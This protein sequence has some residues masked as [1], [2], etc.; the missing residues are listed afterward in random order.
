MALD[1]ATKGCRRIC[2]QAVCEVKEA[3]LCA[4]SDAGI[5][6]ADI[7]QLD[8]SFSDLSDPFEKL[9]TAYMRERFYKE[10]FNYKVS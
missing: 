3:V 1:E 9:S 4:L 7:P 2:K 6:S 5:N 10:H 8:T